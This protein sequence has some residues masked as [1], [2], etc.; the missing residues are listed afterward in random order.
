MYFSGGN[1]KNVVP[2]KA[3]TRIY[4]CER[5]EHFYHNIVKSS[6]RITKY[7]GV[8]FDIILNEK[9]V[10]IQAMGMGSHASRPE[11]GKNAITGLVA[12]LQ[13]LPLRGDAAEKLSSI[14][15]IFPYG[16]YY[17]EVAEICHED[18]L[19]GKLTISLNTLKVSED[20]FLATFDSR[21]PICAD[22]KSL[23]PIKEKISKAG[24]KG[25]YKFNKAHYTSVESE[26]V[27]TLLACY[28]KY[29]GEKGNC[30]STGGGTYVHNL[31]NAVA[32]GF[33]MPEEEN[34]MHGANEWT[35]VKT[36]LTGGMIYT[37]AIISLCQ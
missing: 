32:F 25:W 27:K 8:E 30:L 29:T 26:L 33:S 6:H 5:K 20:K 23:R 18:N 35:Y 34:N 17:G 37:E 31:K 1:Q 13:E 16:D 9:G 36:L 2:N 24:F 21:T 3:E 28:E 15:R 11:Q 7:T 10:S 12:L 14:Y 22:E 4:V 19:A